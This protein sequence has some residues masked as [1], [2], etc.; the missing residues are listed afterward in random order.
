MNREGE[1]GAKPAPD[2][3]AMLDAE[4]YGRGIGSMEQLADALAGECDLHARQI[5]NHLKD[6]RTSQRSGQTFSLALLVAV[7]LPALLNAQAAHAGRVLVEP[8]AGNAEA[9]N[10]AAVCESLKATT[11]AI[12][13]FSQITSDG[14][15]TAE[16]SAELLRHVARAQAALAGLVLRAENLPGRQQAP[17]RIRSVS[18]A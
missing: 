2:F 6:W 13:Q 12:E 5:Y 7:R 8:A 17:A 3:A 14:H 18:G 15:V 11:A 9:S 16:E 1:Q 10:M 4:L